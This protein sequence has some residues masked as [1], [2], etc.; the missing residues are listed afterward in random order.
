MN[1]TPITSVSIFQRQPPSVMVDVD[2]S[3]ASISEREGSDDPDEIEKRFKTS[4]V[5]SCVNFV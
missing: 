3:T 4:Y 5:M 1:T 2:S